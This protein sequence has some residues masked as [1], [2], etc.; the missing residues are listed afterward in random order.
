[1]A[2][3]GPAAQH[4]LFRLH[5]HP[6]AQNPGNV[7]HA[8]R[9]RQARCPSTSTPCARP[10]K[11][12]SSSTCCNTTPPTK[13]TSALQSDRRRPRSGR[14][15]G[16]PGAGPLHEPAPA[17]HRPE[18][19][20]H[21]RTLPPSSPATRSTARPKRWSSPAPAC[22]PSATKKRSTSYLQEKGY[23]D[24]KALVAFSGTFIDPDDRHQLH[25][26]SMNGF[27]EKELPERFAPTNTN[28]CS[29]PRSTRPAS[30]NRCCTP[31]MSI[32]DSPTCSAC[33]PSPASTAPTPAKK[34]PSSSTSPT[35]EDEIQEAFKPYYEQTTLSGTTDPNKLYDLKIQIENHQIIWRQEV[36]AFARV[37]FKSQRIG[38]RRDHGRLNSYIDPAVERFGL[39]KKE[40]GRFPNA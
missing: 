19:R 6:Q 23:T 12:A 11:N 4:Q 5:R 18:D 7:R 38:R 32:S 29:W 36:D 22:T 26:S 24:I 40:A 33:R 21:R 2:G 16:G 25:R 9:R 20:N 31:C 10:S 15:E 30:T 13:P 35:S 14:E 8:R 1:M 39:T 28:C 34:T 37:F 17:Q 3:A 27:S